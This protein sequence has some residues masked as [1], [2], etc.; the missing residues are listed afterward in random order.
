MA[1][2]EGCSE[3]PRESMDATVRPMRRSQRGPRLF[4][5]ALL[6][7]GSVS[8]C[9]SIPKG[10]A[11]VDEIEFSGNEHLDGD[12]LEERIATAETPRFVGLFEGLIYDYEIFD[13]FVLQR[14]LQRIARYYRARGFYEA[15][16]RAGR[17]LYDDS[18]HVRVEIR[19]KEGPR[20][21]VSR[22][23]LSGLDAVAPD[24]QDAVRSRL[25]RRLAVGAPFEEKPFEQAEEDIKRALTDRGY[26]LASVERSAHVDIPHHFAAVSYSVTPRARARFGEVRIEGLGP[27][28]EA[29]VRRALKLRIQQPYSTK[30]IEAARQALLDL[31]VFSSV[32]IDPQLPKPNQATES[33][34]VP[35]VVRVEP[36]RLR[37]LRLGGGAELDVVRAGVHLLAG[38]ESRNFLGGLRRLS[39]EFR[40]GLVFYPTRIPSFNKPTHF[41]P[42]EKFQLQ[43]EQPAFLEGRTTGFVRGNYDVFPMLFSNQVDPK[44]PILGYREGRGS[45]GVYR[46]F[47]PLTLRPSE[48]VQR[49]APFTYAGKLDSA[50]RPALISYVELLS[51]V[52]FRDDPVQPHRGAWFGNDLEVSG[53]GGDTRDLKVQPTARGFIPMGKKLTLALRGTVGFLFPFNYGETLQKNA[54]SGQPPPGVDRVRWVRDSQLVF[55][56]AFFSGGPN[57]N[58]GYPLR[59]IGPHGIQPFLSPNLQSAQLAQECAQGN[60]EYQARCALPLGGLSLWEASVEARYRIS[61][62]L[63]T[64]LFCD[65]SDVSQAKVQLRFTR[66]H[67]SCGTGLRYGTPVGPIRLDIGYRIPGMQVLEK[68]LPPSVGNPGTIFGLPIAVNVAVGEMF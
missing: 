10:R 15:E 61:K 68:D 18:K 35:L 31:G 40:P 44:A 7:L 53:V 55:L 14:D 57:S 4:A 49:D 5:T 3:R 34:V 42:E 54:A 47:G 28:P 1:W 65:A 20:T 21:Y 24:V 22:L 32:E 52:D 64:V 51:N 59:G 37:T 33:P 48:N 2:F 41:L 29:P 58:R 26:A 13:R 11:A 38:W 67:L 6:L 8:A 43:F 46:S 45:V 27:I 66:P 19:V 36:A 25:E 12:E 9:T 30:E 23:T 16:V 56:R 39:I 17:V 63:S 50:L 60:P 62:P